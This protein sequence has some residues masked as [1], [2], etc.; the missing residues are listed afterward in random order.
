MENMWNMGSVGVLENW[1]TERKTERTGT[2][3]RY[4]T[5]IIRH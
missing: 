1:V 3:E 5:S 2:R 4:V